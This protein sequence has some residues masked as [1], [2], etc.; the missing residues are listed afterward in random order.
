[1]KRASRVVPSQVT[2]FGEGPVKRGLPAFRMVS[3][4][5]AVA[6]ALST[7]TAESWA[8]SIFVSGHDSDFH[9]SQGPNAI[10]ARDI[11]N[12]ALTF[13]R[14]GNGAPILFIQ[15]NTSNIGLGDHVDSALGL[16]ASG[17]TAGNIAGNHYVTV[18]ATNFLTT[19][20]SL[21]SA[22]FVPSDHGGTLTGDDLQA[23]N[24]R[25]ADIVAYLNAG[26]GLVAFAEDGDRVPASVGPQPTNFGFL[27]FLVTSAALSIFEGNNQLTAFGSSLGLTVNDINGNFSHNI[28]TSTG[29]MNVVDMFAN[30]Q[31][32]SLAYRGEI[33]T[34]GVVP[35]PGSLALLGLGVA[36][37]AL[38]R[39]KRAT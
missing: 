29:G 13:T 33:S 32:L 1:M 30:G 27:P 8:G 15:S 25:A 12:D 35:E 36:G 26:G 2:T 6:I 4:C 34:G 10:G 3:R 31:I 21:Y 14:N 37:I 24:S 9:A 39:R 17:Y 5:A 7:A 22:I 16:Q 11:I 38:S 23:L 28:F 20:L 18:N 19:D